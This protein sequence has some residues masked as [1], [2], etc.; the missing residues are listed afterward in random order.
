MEQIT[1]SKQEYF[2]LYACMIWMRYHVDELSSKQLHFVAKSQMT[3]EIKEA[4]MAELKKRQHEITD[5]IA[6][7]ENDIP[8]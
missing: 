4:A 8:A 7:L 6:Q 1:I 2:Q 3:A 5:A